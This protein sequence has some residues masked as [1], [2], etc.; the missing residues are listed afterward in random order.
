MRRD[1]IP[2]AAAAA[3]LA[4]ASPAAGQA[5]FIPAVIGQTVG[6][7]AASGA[8]DVKCLLN[9]RPIPPT[10]I[11]EARAGAE[12]VMRD[13]LRL[14]GAG[15]RTDVSAAFTHKASLRYWMR[16]GHDTFVSEVEDP[17]AHAIA[18][19]RATLSA[20]VA[21]VRAG[22]GATAVGLWRVEAAPGEPVVHYRVNFR[23]EDKA[24]RITRM[25]LVEP[26]AEPDPV[27]YYCH[28]PGDSEAYA[29]A[30]AAQ[31]EAEA[32]RGGGG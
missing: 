12:A 31:R 30:R 25:D 10:A 13:Y 5:A 29:A 2:A 8:V 6:M 23:R 21:F 17:F 14:A 22:N 26:P 1:W 15:P 27:A 7:M 28:A 16:H 11:A 18:D 4:S 19:G 20:P 32:A 9:K 3:L 24:W